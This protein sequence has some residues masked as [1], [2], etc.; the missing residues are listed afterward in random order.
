MGNPVPGWVTRSVLKRAAKVFYVTPNLR[1]YMQDYEAKL[2]FL[3]NPVEIDGTGGPAPTHIAK[4]LVF[5]RLDSIK[6]IDQIF[7]AME[8]LR[9]MA[10]VSAIHWGPLA[11]DYV[12]DYKSV[13][14]FLQMTPHDEIGGLL[15]QFDLVIGQMKQGIL[16][17]MEI[18]ALAAG[19]PLITGIDWA[20]YP[21]DPP[22]VIAA[23]DP[24]GII[25]AVT[26]LRDD[27][28]ELARL[29][30]AGHEWAVRNHGYAQYLRRLETAYFGSG[31]RT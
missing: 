18:E 23:S 9:T 20:L 28:G 7:P 19:R 13:V 22:P 11:K 24:D 21:E 17:L 3:P 8:R 5:T 26:R 15:A 2:V 31:A 12:R 29:S 1:A 30:R 6:G 25:A 27:G 14:R 4:V 10:E 16:S